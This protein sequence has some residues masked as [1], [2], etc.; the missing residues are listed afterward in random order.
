VLPSLRPPALPAVAPPVLPPP[1]ARAAAAPASTPIAPA[2]F[3][4]FGQQDRNLLMQQWDIL[5]H[6][7]TAIAHYVEARV[8]EQVDKKR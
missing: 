6:L 3:A 4:R 1:T 8:I 5:Q 2:L 7:T